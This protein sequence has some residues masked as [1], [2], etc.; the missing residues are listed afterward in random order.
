MPFL[1][2]LRRK[3]APAQVSFSAPASNGVDNLDP[4]LTINGITDT[5]V[6]RYKGGDATAAI[7]PH[8]TYGEQLTISASGTLP[9]PNELSPLLGAN[10]DSILYRAGRQ[11]NAANNT[12]GDV[13][14]EDIVFEVVAQMPN[15]TFSGLFHKRI[16]NLVGW[17]VYCTN[18]TQLGCE[19]IDGSAV[20]R[21][22]SSN[23]IGAFTWFHGMVFI[24]KSGS[25]MIFVNADPGVATAISGAVGSLTSAT[26]MG[27]G[28]FRND[29]TLASSSRIAY[30][31]MWKRVNWLDTHNQAAIA[32]QRA[33]KMFGSYMTTPGIAPTLSTLRNSSAVMIK[34]TGS[35]KV[36][37]PVAA[38]W[39]RVSAVSDGSTTKTALTIEGQFTNDLQY[40]EDTSQAQYSVVG[41]TKA[42]NA[43]S[44]IGG[45]DTRAT[46]LTEDAA[47]TE[48]YLQYGSSIGTTS[49]QAYGGSFFVK[50]IG[51]AV[52]SVAM[53]AFHTFDVNLT[54]GVVSNTGGTTTSQLHRAQAFANGW[55][56]VSFSGVGTATS[57]AVLRIKANNGSGTTYAGNSAAALAVF[58]LSF[59]AT[60]GTAVPFLQPYIRTSG[61][62]ATQLADRVVYAGLTN[63]F[64]QGTIVANALLGGTADTRTLV[65]L[66]E[67]GGTDDSIKLEATAANLLK[68]DVTDDTVSR[69]SES[70]GAMTAN[71]WKQARFT[72]SGAVGAQ[73]VDNVLGA[74]N[75]MASTPIE[76]T[77]LEI[78]SSGSGTNPANGQVAVS[79]YNKPTMA[80]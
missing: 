20:N 11:H 16:G 52:C 68:A 32:T 46:T 35:G 33:A 47:N 76:Q 34:E 12:L 3:P 55:W 44:P 66:R 29:T 73:Y 61:A 74:T 41:V 27:L 9:T 24:D 31:A 78:G 7:W 58:G 38:K 60:N 21:S 57:G 45:T 4:S 40:S 71:V 77:V 53:S 30:A 42:I 59:D 22:A 63:N 65:T 62:A 19:I 64:G 26:P 54:T 39:T 79:I 14:T 80:G 18:T 72:W 23:A 10:D 6:F 13:T 28:G 75:A 15:G 51:R 37:F 1:P 69:Y 5:P 25:M 48:H 2:P 70:A 49:G 50:A 67:A 17:S 56:H 43:D 36:L 8:W